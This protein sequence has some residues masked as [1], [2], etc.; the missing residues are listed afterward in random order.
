MN[1]VNL[2]QTKEVNE[3]KETFRES[4]YSLIND[5]KG[6]KANRLKMSGFLEGFRG[7]GLLGF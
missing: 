6:A 3:W 7:F 2:R 4:A 5:A 1:E